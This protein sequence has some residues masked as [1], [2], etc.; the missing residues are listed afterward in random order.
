MM[1]LSKESCKVCCYGIGK[2]YQFVLVISLENF[3][4]FIEAIK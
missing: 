4:I 1:G 2:L 3:K